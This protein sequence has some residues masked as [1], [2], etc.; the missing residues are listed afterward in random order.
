MPRSIIP[1]LF[2][3]PLIYK[4]TASNNQEQKTE[5]LNQYLY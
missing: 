1:A 3:L 5:M 4:Y 2:S